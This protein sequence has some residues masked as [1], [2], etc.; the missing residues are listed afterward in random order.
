MGTLTIPPGFLSRADSFLNWQVFIN[1]QSL[2]SLY[3]GVAFISGQPTARISF[4]LQP[5]PVGDVTIS[6]EL[7]SDP[8]P[9]TSTT[10]EIPIR[11]RA[12]RGQIVFGQDLISAELPY[13]QHFQAD[14][15]LALPAG[16]EVEGSSIGELGG[17]SPGPLG[18]RLYFRDAGYYRQG[19]TFPIVI[20]ASGVQP[21]TIVAFLRSAPA[22]LD[23]LAEPAELT[24]RLNPGEEPQPS[25]NLLL[26]AFGGH[27]TIGVS[28]PDT[29]YLTVS[30]YTSVHPGAPVL[31]PVQANP[32]DRTPRF[33]ETIL[34][35]SVDRTAQPVRVSFE[36]YDRPGSLTLS[37]SPGGRI[38]ASPLRDTYANGDRVLLTA[39]PDRYYRFAGWSGDALVNRNPLDV[40]I[41]GPVRHRAEFV[42]T[43][44]TPCSPTVTPPSI[45]A[46]P[47]G[48]V[49]RLE[50]V[51]QPACNWSVGDLPSW[52]RI[53]GMI[54]NPGGGTT[55]SY[56]VEANPGNSP[57]SA[58]ARI[59]GTSLPV[60]QSPPACR[61]I[62]PFPDRPLASVA[63][64]LWQ[65]PIT[66]SGEACP[67]PLRASNPW[68]QP[69]GVGEFIRGL[70]EENPNHFPRTAYLYIGGYRL[71]S[72]QR[73]TLPLMPFDDLPVHLDSSVYAALLKHH[74][75]V[76]PCEANRF[77]PATPL[78]R[79]AIAP[80]IVR[81][82]L[83]SDTFPS[84]QTPAFSD[85]PNSHPQFRYIQKLA[86]L[87]F[88]TG[89]GNG[90]YCPDRLITRGELAVFLIRAGARIGPGAVIPHPAKPF[91]RDVPEGAPFFPFIQKLRQWGA[92]SGCNATDFCPSASVTRE[93]AATLIVR[94]LL[95]PSP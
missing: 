32:I 11:L 7:S 89:C 52:V 42:L 93:Q 12:T 94:A 72:I 73:G 83:R 88:T 29:R 77:C 17:I 44:D 2:S 24:F 61:G 19:I 13:N 91:F 28:S 14:I 41:N 1:G 25:Q 6:A 43:G 20:R 33:A 81:A 23:F 36:I 16:S 9:V 58:S 30:T 59:G 10:V 82:T 86:E 67:E 84:S 85:V 75:I 47:D 46:P 78:T 4:F 51:T 21:R 76:E 68:L 55:L 57:R 45:E 48:D 37:S 40:R 54:E 26:R 5:I 15:P 49:G 18:A 39:V 64:S 35:F 60:R 65:P 95:T 38:V 22:P 50:I 79:A 3:G 69:S 53:T 92:T 34:P 66:Q 8:I 74:N 70:Q 31:L 90:R 62:R 63:F 56:L 71:P 80:W 87:G 27:K